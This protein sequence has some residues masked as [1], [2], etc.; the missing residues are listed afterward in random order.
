MSTFKPSSEDLF[1]KSCI[2]CQGY[3]PP[4]SLDQATRLLT[5]LGNNWSLNEA[6]YLNKTYSFPDFM[7]AMT[8]A[9]QIARLSEKE[10]HHPDLNIGWGYCSVTIWTHKIKGLTE[11]DFILAAKIES[12]K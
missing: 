10:G 7:T 12:L 2:P 5:K 6:G 8:F 11:S 3:T 1:N 9:N 4:L